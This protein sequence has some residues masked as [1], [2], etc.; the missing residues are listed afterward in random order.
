MLV[1]LSGIFVVGISR[2]T[3]QSFKNYRKTVDEQ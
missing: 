2:Y 3:C 1:S